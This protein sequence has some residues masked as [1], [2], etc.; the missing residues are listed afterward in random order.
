[1]NILI[2]L[3][4]RHSE[5]IFSGKKKVE[6][7][8]RKMNVEVGALVWI[9]V[10]Q[11]IGQIVGCARIS[12]VINSSPRKI[13]DKHQAVSG[14]SKKEFFE[15][16]LGSD[17]ATALVLDRCSKLASGIRLADLRKLETGFHPPQFFTRLPN[18]DPVLTAILQ[19]AEMQ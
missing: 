11:P 2:S 3:E 14:L 18:A 16:F 17:H 19:V 9:Y 15:Y 13:W 4:N 6:L 1:M 10:K 12:Q 8:R 5:N 7:R